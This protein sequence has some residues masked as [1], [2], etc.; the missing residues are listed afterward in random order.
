[1]RLSL[2]VIAFL[3]V[4]PVSAQK[5]APGFDA[6]EYISLF[7]LETFGNSIADSNLRKTQ[8]DVYERVYRS[9][10]VGLKNRWAFYRR[11]D[12][13]GVISI[14]GTVPDAKSWLANFYMAMVPAIG[15][16]QL[17]DSTVFHYKL[18]NDSGAAVHAGWT[19]ALGFMAP[20][21]QRLI[22]EQYA[23]GVKEYYIFG[24]S[25]GGA[26]AYLMRS[27]LFYLQ[28][29]GRL[30]GDIVFKTYCSAAPKPGNLA[31]AYDYEFINRGGWA[32]TVVNAEDWVPESPYTVQ[33]IQDMNKV[34]PLIHA[35]DALK[36]QKFILR[37]I[38][39]HYYNKI[40]RRPRKL[41]KMYNNIFGNTLYGR[42]VSKALPGFDK[43]QYASTTN[44]M[45]AGTPIVLMPDAD[46]RKRFYFKKDYFVHH[47][48]EAYYDL[49]KKQYL[50]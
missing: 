8:K 40:E 31:Y 13:V 18:A 26:I 23:K 43:P 3:F 47:S 35:K 4:F 36:K 7:S 19:V 46:Y 16:L 48:F 44:Y 38:G 22:T 21:V 14:R 30:P 24:H 37:L 28:Q 42:V 10:E 50:K 2:F 32:Y 27:Y 1:M 41:Q 49:L 39:N 11:N 15:S 5:I 34:N 29:D 20:D 33:K 45:R 12:D 25:Q 6:K 9:P 17:N